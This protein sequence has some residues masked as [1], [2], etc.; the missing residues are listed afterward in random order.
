MRTCLA[1]HLAP[2]LL[3]L[4]LL[5]QLGSSELF[6]LAAAHVK[7]SK[8]GRKSDS[9]PDLSSHFPDTCR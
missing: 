6:I 4:L 2:L 5:D 1:S 9:F 7:H 8:N 3:L